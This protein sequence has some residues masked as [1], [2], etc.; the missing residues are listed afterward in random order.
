[1]YNGRQGKFYSLNCNAPSSKCL[2]VFRVIEIKT[3]ND[4]KQVFRDP[5]TL[6]HKP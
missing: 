1:M 4:V 3:Q 6:L 2:T 5:L